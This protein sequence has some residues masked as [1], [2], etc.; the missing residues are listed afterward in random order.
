MTHDDLK[1]GILYTCGV[2][3]IGL[4]LLGAYT[5]DTSTIMLA[6]VSFYFCYLG[7]DGLAKKEP[8]GRR[9]H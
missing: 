4:L 6:G 1:F 7:V 2:L 8:N 5:H 9:N 3:N